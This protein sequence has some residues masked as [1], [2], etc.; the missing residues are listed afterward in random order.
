MPALAHISRDSDSEHLAKVATKSRTHSI[1][2][3]FPKERNCDVRLRTKISEASCRR[4]TGEALPRAEKF[5]D[6]ITADHKVLNEGCESRDNHLHGVVVQDLATQWIQSYPWKTKSS[7]ET[8]NS[9]ES[10]RPK[11]VYTDKSMEF[12]RACEVYHGITALQH[13]IDWRQMASL[14]EPFDE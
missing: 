5:R 3:H 14:K 8:E 11:V 4:R 7:H 6:L 10:H 1:C 9:L 12:G 2:T 13:L